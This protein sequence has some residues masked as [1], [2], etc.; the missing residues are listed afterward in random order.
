[1]RDEV[2]VE[3]AR[4]I[5]D[6]QVLTEI[7]SEYALLA[8][9][10][11]F[12]RVQL[13]QLVNFRCG[14]LLSCDINGLSHFGLDLWAVH[15]ESG[16]VATG[17]YSLWLDILIV[18]IFIEAGVAREWFEGAAEIRRA[19]AK[20]MRF[21]NGHTALFIFQIGHDGFGNLVYAV[22]RRRFLRL[23]LHTVWLTLLLWLSWLL[24]VVIIETKRV[25][26]ISFEVGDKILWFRR[27][28]LKLDKAVQNGT[29]FTVLWLVTETV[30]EALPEKVNQ[31]SSRKFFIA[32]VVETVF[33]L[34]RADLTEALIFVLLIVYLDAG[35]F[36]VVQE[37][38]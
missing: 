19:T 33:E 3:L 30:A 1:L 20:A 16:I 7:A 10:D 37:K 21:R 17:S 25:W 2:A 8:H 34:C 38:N 13:G 24:V 14:T 36:A 9:L 26:I 32:Q 11:C 18:Q 29:Q 23:V 28:Y 27:K 6:W 15:R 4:A 22:Y 5:A 31:I 35:Q 12:H